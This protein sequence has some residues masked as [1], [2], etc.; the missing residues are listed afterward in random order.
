M[1]EFEL[2]TSGVGSD[3]STSSATTTALVL[4]CL[5]CK[6]VKGKFVTNFTVVHGA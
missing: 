1:T 3:R 4:N 2:R 6:F 5:L